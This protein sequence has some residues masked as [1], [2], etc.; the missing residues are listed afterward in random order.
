MRRAAAEYVGTFPP[1]TPEWHAARATGIGASEA[2]AVLGL[3]PWESE[4]SLW[5][6]KAG[7]IGPPPESEEMTW[8]RYLEAP[9]ASRFAAAHPELRIVRTGTWRSRARH[10]QLC[11][12]DRMAFRTGHGRIPVEVKW[13][14]YGDG[15]GKSGS[16]EIPTHYR[17]QV[18]HQC[19]VLGA[20]YGW[21]AALVGAE[22]R[23]YRIEADLL[24]ITLLRGRCETFQNSLPGETTSTGRPPKIDDTDF[25]FRAIKE[26]HPDVDGRDVEVP[27]GLADRARTA[28]LD[29]DR[30]GDALQQV[31]NDLLA[32]MGTA[33][34]AV[35]VDEPVAT[36]VASRGSI[37]LRL[38]KPPKP[39]GQ[40]L[41]EAL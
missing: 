19:D 11:N 36:R 13:S 4:Y 38:T 32:A 23:E 25:T 33:R 3:S 20:P 40:K 22:Y 37:Q 21:L 29:A 41:T 1:N 5:Q 18:L 28:Q 12:P 30:A 7:R 16:E 2:A 31:K 26:L 24:D 17:C 14:P 35:C 6:R 8:G 39:T 10:W 15:W 27:F 34:R 9:I